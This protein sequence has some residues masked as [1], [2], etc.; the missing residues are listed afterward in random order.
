MHDLDRILQVVDHFGAVALV[1][2]NM[3][4]INEGN[5]EKIGE[6]CKKMGVEV[7]G[8]IPFDQHVIEAIVAGKPVVEHSPNSVASKDIRRMWNRIINILG[9]K[10]TNQARKVVITHK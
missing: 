2:I 8:K 7:V 9:R 3:C 10:P 1:C 4:D 6:L 5:S